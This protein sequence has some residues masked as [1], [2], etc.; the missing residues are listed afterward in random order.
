MKVNIRVEENVLADLARGIDAAAYLRTLEAILAEGLGALSA[1]RERAETVEISLSSLS[2]PEMRGVNME[3]R[4]IDSATDVLSFPLWEE[5]GVFDPPAGWDVLPLGDIVVCPDIIAKSA[6]DAKKAFLEE[7][8]LVLCHGALHLCG[9]D[10]DSEEREKEM[11][12]QQN[13]MVSRFMEGVA[14]A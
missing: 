14:D 4:E 2:E 3:Y 9:F 12:E 8:T 11:W 5:E 6:E 10:H 13:S 7:L 1:L